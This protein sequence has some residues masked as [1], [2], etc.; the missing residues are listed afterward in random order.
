MNIMKTFRLLAICALV[1]AAGCGKDPKIDKVYNTVYINSAASS[2]QGSLTQGQ[3]VAQGT[4]ITLAYTNGLG[5]SAQVLLPEVNGLYCDPIDVRLASP[6]SSDN[7]NGTVEIPV[8]GTPTASGSMN[9]RP[10][11]RVG[12]YEVFISI[13]ATVTPA[14]ALDA[15]ASVVTGTFRIGQA[16]ANGN[17][18][19]HYT[20]YA[21]QEVTVS[22]DEVSGI[23]IAEF[24]ASLPAAPSG[25]TLDVPVTGTPSDYGTKTLKITMTQGDNTYTADIPVE[26]AGDIALDAAG[27]TVTGTLSK[28]VE[29]SDVKI[30][31]HYTAAE[32]QQATISIDL[33]NGI[34]CSAFDAALPA[35]ED[36]TVDVP[37][38]GTPVSDGVTNLVV[39][40]KI[41]S[42]NYTATIP[43]TV[44]S[45]VP[46]IPFEP[47]TFTYQ[48]LEYT[49]IFIDV[50][51]NGYV[52][53]G[54]RLARPQHRSR[55]GR[56]GRLRRRRHQRRFDRPDVAIRQA[57]RSHR[58]RRFLPDRLRRY[59][60]MDGLPG[61]VRRTDT[62]SVQR[63]HRESNRRNDQR[64]RG[65]G[66]RRHH[67]DADELRDEAADWRLAD[68]RRHAAAGL[69]RSGRL[70]DVE[71]GQQHRPVESRYQQQFGVEYR[72]QLGRCGLAIAG[73]LH[74]EISLT[75]KIQ[76]R[77][78]ARK[79]R[80]S[81]FQPLKNTEK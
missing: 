33:T 29:L 71:Q 74:Q 19:L 80:L 70:L 21:N 68:Q 26:I 35:A 30:A 2:F 51:G 12:E 45:D 3:A 65:F 11:I 78:M 64:Q 1:L 75:G 8:S 28:G 47:E 36:G 17:I 63:R 39:I 22:A 15:A 81:S 53:P 43:V 67:A 62:G 4:K 58:I 44:R 7:G 18:A 56:S 6:T 5:K 38:S 24:T 76:R 46:G 73:T 72:S 52:D 55:F 31:L 59:R 32:E 27:S 61:R 13:P 40:V 48:G 42:T 49:T 54:R 79:D 9:L 41:G 69:R 25:G 60:R 20:S 77:G 10:V 34:N 23:S 14:I 57:V 50:N 16:I 37:L 66:Q